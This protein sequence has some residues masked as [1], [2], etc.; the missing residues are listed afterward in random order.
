MAITVATGVVTVRPDIDENGVVR[1][2]QTAGTNTG[3]AFVRGLDG[4]IRDSQG[5]LVNRATLL[6]DTMGARMAA[7]F[8][9]PDRFDTLARSMGVNIVH[10]L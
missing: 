3:N 4:R 5:N 6:G 1:A 8:L 10:Q 7:R 2:G 9:S